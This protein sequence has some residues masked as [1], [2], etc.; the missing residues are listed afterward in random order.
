MEGEW[1][2]ETAGGS[3]EHSTW[4]Q[5][6]QFILTAL[7]RTTVSLSLVQ[8]SPTLAPIGLYIASGQDSG[9]HAEPTRLLHAPKDSI[10][11]AVSP[12][13]VAQID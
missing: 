8:R 2:E 11:Y 10:L 12:W 6:P 7:R 5:N 1:G 13:A 3:F 9:G 4:R